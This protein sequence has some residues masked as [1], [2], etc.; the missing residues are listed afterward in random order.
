[1]PDGIASASLHMHLS[2]LVS[3]LLIVDLAACGGGGTTGMTPTPVRTTASVSGTCQGT[4]DAPR[5]TFSGTFAVTTSGVV[6]ASATVAGFS[7]SM[8]LVILGYNA[9]SVSGSTCSAQFLPSPL[10]PLNP[11]TSSVAATPVIA[12]HWDS[13]PV[14]TYCLNVAIVPVPDTIPPYSWTATVTHP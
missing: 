2:T 13:I 7:G 14:G 5:C 12:G 1:M 3:A 8:A 9:A 11:P 4:H 6:D 10:S